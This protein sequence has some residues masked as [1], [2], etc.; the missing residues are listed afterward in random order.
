M[1]GPRP[2]AVG[3]GTSVADDEPVEESLL[4]DLAGLLPVHR[5]GWA[6][7][8]ADERLV[9]LAEP[10]GVRRCAHDDP[11]PGAPGAADAR[12]G[13][14]PRGRGARAR[15]HH[16]QHRRR[17]APGRGPRPAAREYLPA[18]DA[19][20][21]RP[22]RAARRADPVGAR[23]G[24]VRAGGACRRGGVAVPRHREPAARAGGRH[25]VGRGPRPRRGDPRR[26]LR[27]DD[28]RPG[29]LPVPR[30]LGTGR[31]P[32]PGHCADGGPPAAHGRLV[33]RARRPRP[34][35]A[36]R[37]RSGPARPAAPGR[38]AGARGVAARGDGAGRTARPAAHRPG[39][40]AAPRGARRRRA[41][42]HRPAHGRPRR[43]GPALARSAGSSPSRATDRRTPRGPAPASG[44]GCGR[45]SSNA[46]AGPTCASGAPTSTATR[47]ARWRGSSRR[48][49]RPRTR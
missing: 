15:V 13:R 37:R 21:R 16:R 34:G 42:R 27:T 44:T 24:G 22:D 5:L 31:R 19:R 12:A 7:A 35:A 40:A 28:L 1:G 36:A 11:A 14:R 30:P 10:V 23:R 6:H 25:G 9:A 38:T 29:A 3:T 8:Y 47:P 4:D 43:H 41:L 32:L 48:S 17:G 39:Y 2:F 46:A 26:R 33:H 49:G 45:R 18:R 20:G